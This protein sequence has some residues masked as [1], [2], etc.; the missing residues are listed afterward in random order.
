MD[1]PVSKHQVQPEKNEQA[2]AGR[3]GRTYLARPSSQAQTGTGKKVKSFFTIQLTTSRISYHT[4]LV[5][6][7]LRVLTVQIPQQWYESPPL[8]FLEGGVF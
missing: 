5:H 2:D 6:A 8:R 4:R 7:V 1:N 3:D